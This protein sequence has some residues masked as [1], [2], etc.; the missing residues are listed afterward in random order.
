LTGAALVLALAAA[1]IAG[2]TS[3][4]PGPWNDWKT[5]RLK[6]RKML[7]FS[8]RVEMRVKTEEGRRIFETTTRARF[9]GVEMNRTETRTVIDPETGRTLEYRS[10]SPKRGRHYVFGETGYTVKKLK[11][12]EGFDAPL[13]E[14]TVKSETTYA[15]PVDDEGRP[16]A[17]YDY[18]GMLL[19]LSTAGLERPGDEVLFH[20][21]TSK[22]P[23]AYRVKV[24]EVRRKS[25]SFTDL[26]KSAKREDSLRESRLRIAPDDPD[27]APEGF[28]NMEGE[29]ELWV[30]SHSRTVLEINGRIPKVG[31]VEIAL[32]SIG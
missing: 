28:L 5:L 13:E 24:S 15:Y 31:R 16:Y 26:R 19:R 20:V 18:Y 23:R 6:A 9:M 14:W 3:S 32:D 1:G 8:G 17:V 22:G 27:K 29:T 30:E 11:P 25:R 2:T 12:T 4:S 21:A 7:L 10:L